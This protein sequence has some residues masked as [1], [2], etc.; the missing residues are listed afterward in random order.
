MDSIALTSLK[1]TSK[2]LLSERIGT[3]GLVTSEPINKMKV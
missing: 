2:S 1:T 3:K